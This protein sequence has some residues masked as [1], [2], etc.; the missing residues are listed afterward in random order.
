MPLD[1]YEN[2]MKSLLEMANKHS[3]V[4]IEHHSTF[5]G[6]IALIS[7]LRRCAKRFGIP[8]PKIHICL[9]GAL[10]SQTQGR[11]GQHVATLV[12]TLANTENSQDIKLPRWALAE[13]R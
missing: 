4:C 3:I 2:E 9:S 11:V 13:I 1:E 6:P 7:E 10:L 12:Q 8:L 5:A